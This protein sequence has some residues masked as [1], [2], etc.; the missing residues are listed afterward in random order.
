MG[1]K[2]LNFADSMF[3]CIFVIENMFILL[4]IP[5]QDATDNTS[6]LFQVAAGRQ[7]VDKPLPEPMMMNI[8]DL[9]MRHYGETS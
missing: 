3:K 1:K 9:L 4:Q 6:S 5:E 7:T 8:A 2:G